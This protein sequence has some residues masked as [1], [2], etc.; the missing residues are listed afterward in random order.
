MRQLDVT[1]K[2]IIGVLMMMM[3]EE[4]AVVNVLTKIKIMK[5]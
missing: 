3:L 5:Y 2:M 4:L 1:I